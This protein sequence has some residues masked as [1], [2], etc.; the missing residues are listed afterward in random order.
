MHGL[1]PFSI[2]GG[3][4]HAINESRRRIVLYLYILPRDIARGPTRVLREVVHDI[5]VALATLA[6]VRMVD[7][8][9]GREIVPHRAGDHAIDDETV[10]AIQDEVV[11]GIGLDALNFAEVRRMLPGSIHKHRVPESEPAGSTNLG[12]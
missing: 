4:P 10:S 1:H 6:E 12:S 3:G 11:D 8:C 9:I 5:P 2:L 7:N